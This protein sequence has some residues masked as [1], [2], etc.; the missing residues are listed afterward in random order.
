MTAA[1][2]KRD[3]RLDWPEQLLF[4][5]LETTDL[6]PWCGEIT[7]VAWRLWHPDHGWQPMFSAVCRHT[8]VGAHPDALAVT[9]RDHNTPDWAG[10][11]DPA[12][13][14]GTLM[15]VARDATIVGAA[16]HFD[17]AWL[18]HYLARARWNPPWRHRPIDV[19]QL[20]LPLTGWP[21]PRSLSDTAHALGVPVERFDR[22][23]AAGDVELTVATFH[24]IMDGFAAR[25]IAWP[26]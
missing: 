22:H 19:E 9:G 15:V 18:A 5:D 16:P 14:L 17:M 13:W 21:I 4:L 24:A 7:E 23:T 3:A 25:G 20:A 10:S 26:G 2:C 11:V 1:G 6:R 8:L 12:E